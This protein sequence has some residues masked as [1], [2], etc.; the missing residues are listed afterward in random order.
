MRQIFLDTETTGLS[1]DSGDR[2]VEIGCVEMFNRRLTGNNRHFYLNPERKNN[3]EAVRVH[4]LT[5]EFLADKPLFSA[6]ADDLIAYWAGAEIIIHNAAFDVGFLDAE[7][8]RVGKPLFHAHVA[9]VTDS[10]LMARDMFPGKSNSLDALCK[11]LEVDN[12]SRTLH[13]A[14][15]DAE[16]LAEVYI[17][18]T[19]GQGSLVI[20]ASEGGEGPALELGSQDLSSFALP[21]VV[22]GDAELVAHSEVMKSIDKSG[23]AL[24]LWEKAM[25]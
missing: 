20:D 19:R 12:S 5:D 2:I 14:L 16:L 15:L 22:V 25:A 18:M 6:V 3:E 24:A 17:R 7:L 21:L 11:R 23:E 1:P 10:L 13:G 8:K 4:G 9:S